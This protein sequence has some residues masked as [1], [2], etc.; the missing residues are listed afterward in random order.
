MCVYLCNGG[1]ADV[2]VLLCNTEVVDADG[3][4]GAVWCAWCSCI[5]GMFFIYGQTANR[6]ENQGRTGDQ[7]AEQRTGDDE[8][9]RL[10]RRVADI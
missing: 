10:K 1:E 3:R 9:S 8:E 7:T 6:R 4:L 2:G 5:D